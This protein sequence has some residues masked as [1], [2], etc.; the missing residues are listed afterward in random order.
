MNKQTI[1]I[2]LCLVVVA[3]TAVARNGH[4]RSQ[5]REPQAE[6]FFPARH[7]D[8]MAEI[9]DLTDEQRTA[10][11]ELHQQGREQGVELRKDV[12]RLQN[13]IEGE[14]LSDDPSS[15]TLVDL[16]EKIGALR[17]QL[18]VIRLKTRLAVRDQLTAEQQDQWMLMG[19]KH[20]RHGLHRGHAP[21]CEPSPGSG[22]GHGR[23][24]RL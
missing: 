4:G 8:R 21:Q 16:T 17:T 9:L 11:D 13:Q 20:G 10:I 2:A 7:L 22:H 18:Q 24:N 1:V 5:C 23:G 19:K 14:M 12:A 15:G 3:T 6:A